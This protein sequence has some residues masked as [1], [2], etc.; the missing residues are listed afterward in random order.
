[1]LSYRPIQSNPPQRSRQRGL[2]IVEL[3]VGVAIG[4]F[5]A[6]GAISLTVSNLN[7]N[8]QLLVETRVIQ[9]LRA[10]S[11]VIARDIRRASYWNAASSGLWSAGAGGTPAASNL[12]APIDTSTSSQIIYKYDRPG[13][14]V[15]PAISATNLGFRRTTTVSGINF[16][17]LQNASSGWE[18]LTDPN[19]VHIS[20][21]TI[22]PVSP[23]I[24]VYLDS[25][26]S[27]LTTGKCLLSGLQARP[28][29]DRA[30]VVIRKFTILLR[31]QAVVSG[32]PDTSVT[33]ELQQTVRVRN[34]EIKNPNS[35]PAA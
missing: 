30:Q 22:T 35:C 29:G 16:L 17:Q 19:S 7:R 4:L 21:F 3:L 5:V 32:A 14:V 15:A 24:V 11:D 28:S 12:Y 8:R 34:D 27:C 1:M 13:V 18:D 23:A 2:S 10:A 33:R 6:A 26:C 20:T 25:Y 31:G 9:D